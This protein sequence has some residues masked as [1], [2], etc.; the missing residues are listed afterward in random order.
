[1]STLYVDTINE[2]TSGNGIKI[3]GHVVQ[4]KQTH[5]IGNET[6]TSSSYVDTSLSVTITPKYSDSKIF[7]MVSMQWGSSA[8]D[9][10]CRLVRGS[11]HIGTGNT[12]T[13]NNGFSQINGNV[14]NQYGMETSTINYLDS[15]ATTNA[16]TY[17]VQ[18]TARDGNS[19]IRINNRGYST[20]YGGSSQITVMEIAQ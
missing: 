1:M 13:V 12:G 10:L 4:V 7:V 3:P 9:C 11:T 18:V 17:K 5:Y 8:N 16:T 20:E 14:P 6:T 2:K 19:T 15:P